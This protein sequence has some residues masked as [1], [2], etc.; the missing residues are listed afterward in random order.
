[1]VLSELGFGS[2]FQLPLF[3][4]L[5]DIYQLLA[6]DRLL[7]LDPVSVPQKSPRNEQSFEP[8][9]AIL[10]N[11]NGTRSE[12]VKNGHFHQISLPIGDFLA[13]LLPRDRGL[14][15]QPFR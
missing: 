3:L 2:L 7:G 13:K 5:T 10:A 15:V 11:L 9:L 8:N 14:F 6:F 1:M 12:Q 4:R